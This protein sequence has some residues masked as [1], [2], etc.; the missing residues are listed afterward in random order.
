MSG[1]LTRI[2]KMCY[3][4]IFSCNFLCKISLYSC[5]ILN[6]HWPPHVHFTLLYWFTCMK[7]LT[8]SII[9]HYAF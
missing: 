3:I 7:S 5:K 6:P 4:F 9:V 2:W 1:K 8:L